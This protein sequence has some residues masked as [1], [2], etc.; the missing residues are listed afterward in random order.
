MGTPLPP[1]AGTVKL[2]FIQTLGDDVAVD[3]VL[4][5]L[6]N[7]P[8]PPLTAAQCVT[9]A[10]TAFAQWVAK[11]APRVT[12]HLTL[13]SVE[14]TDL[15]VVGG[16]QGVS[17]TAPTAGTNVTQSAPGGT[18][19]VFTIGTGTRGRSFRGRWFQAGCA[20]VDLDPTTPQLWLSGFQAGFNTDFAAFLALLQT[21]NLQPVI[22]SYYSGKVANPNPL[23]NRRYVPQRRVTPVATIY[24]T[25]TAKLRVASQRRRNA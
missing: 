16:Q 24:S 12:S 20:T 19:M 18:S 11:I 7:L 1:V 4:H 13:T 17:T 5:C 2:R 21:N 14:V 22:V 10:N 9:Y 23:S 8:T 15:S 3:N 6:A 25:S